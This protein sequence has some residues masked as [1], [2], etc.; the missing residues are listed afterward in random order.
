MWLYI[1]L[2]F[3]FQILEHHN[4]SKDVKQTVPD[5]VIAIYSIIL[6]RCGV[7]LDEQSIF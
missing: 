6:S 2:N 3:Q 7:L 5:F 1:D 4:E